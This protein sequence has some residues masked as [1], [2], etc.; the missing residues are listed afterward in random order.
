MK[1]KSILIVEDEAS[2][3]ELL[4][5]MMRKLDVKIFWA[6]NGRN[7]LKLCLESTFDLILMD[8]KMPGLN[9]YEVTSIIRGNGNTTPIIAQTAYARAEDE[10]TILSKGFN[11]YLAKPI[12]RKKLLATV[13]KYT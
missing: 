9:G 5:A 7:A 6:K 11:G 8:I 3:Y 13:E 12:D 10:Q 4:R 1:Q 2:N